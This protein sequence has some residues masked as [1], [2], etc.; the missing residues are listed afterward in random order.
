MKHLL[1]IVLLFGCMLA[2]AQ[3]PI[4]KPI[5]DCDCKEMKLGESLKYKI[6]FGWFK[7]GEAVISTDTALHEFD[8][9]Q[10][11]YVRFQLETGGILKIFA[12]LNLD[13]DSYVHTK[14]FRPHKS[15]RYTRNGKKSNNQ[16]DEFTYADSIYVAT[17][18]ENRDKTES[19]SFEETGKPF[20]DALSTYMYVRAQNLDMVDLKEMKFYIADELYDFS[21]SPN[22]GL[23]KKKQRHLKSYKINFPPIDEFPSNKT[24]YAMFYGDSNI[25]EEIKLSTS[26]G[27]FFLILDD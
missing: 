15:K 25:P 21:I 19:H 9:E 18:R 4:Q 7:I 17:Y 12:N 8:G 6:K 22:P 27:N 26:D 13:F 1:L 2:T 23:R 10:Y 16:Q 24:S 20:L 11:Y 14:T 3:G 5:E